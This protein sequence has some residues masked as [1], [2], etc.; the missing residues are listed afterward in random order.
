VFGALRGSSGAEAT[1]VERTTTLSAE[2]MKL[3]ANA[4][5]FAL[6]LKDEG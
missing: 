5:K 4:I 1:L 6:D 2:K 3:V